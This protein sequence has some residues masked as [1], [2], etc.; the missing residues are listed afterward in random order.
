MR[1]IE[2]VKPKLVHKPE[3]GSRISWYISTLTTGLVVPELVGRDCLYPSSSCIDLYRLMFLGDSMYENFALCFELFH[4]FKDVVVVS[5]V[6][7]ERERRLFWI[8]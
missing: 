6:F 2:I 1:L 5:A 8:P 3:N 4:H 7:F